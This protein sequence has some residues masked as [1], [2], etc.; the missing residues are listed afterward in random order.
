MKTNHTTINKYIY[1]LKGKAGQKNF[2][3]KYEKII[4]IR[5]NRRST[6]CVI[7][8]HLIEINKEV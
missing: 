6:F 7:R 5:I 1:N 3:T 2:S 8:K 4:L